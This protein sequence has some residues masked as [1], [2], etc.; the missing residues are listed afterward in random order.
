MARAKAA[1]EVFA[2][3]LTT[4]IVPKN[5]K[6]ELSALKCCQRGRR[7]PELPQE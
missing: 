7:I 6:G 3:L 1:L 2:D 5:E 4:R